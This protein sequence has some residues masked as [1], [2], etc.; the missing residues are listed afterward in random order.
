MIIKK[1]LNLVNITRLYYEK[2]LVGFSVVEEINPENGIIV[3]RLL[4]PE[5]LTKINEPNI[6]LH[7]YD[8]QSNPDK[9]LNIGGGVTSERNATMSI[10]KHKLRPSGTVEV[11]RKTSKKKIT[12]EE[13]MSAKSGVSR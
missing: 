2:R 6:L 8:C 13:Y 1:N 10:A 4:N 5:I 12:A 7:Y 9:F 11:G 3:Q